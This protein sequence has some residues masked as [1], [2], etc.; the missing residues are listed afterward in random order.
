MGTIDID[1]TTEP[2][3]PA[4]GIS[5]IYIDSSSKKL[6]TKDD[7]GVVTDYSTDTTDHRALTNIGSNTHAQVD[8]HI[9]S[10]ANPHTVD[11]DDVTP[12]TTKGDIIVE[13]GTNAIRVAVGSNDQVLTADSAEAS[14][15]KWAAVGASTPTWTSF[16]PNLLGGGTLTYT[17]S[18]ARY[19]ITGKLLYMYFDW[20]QTNAGSGAAILT[21]DVPGAVTVLDQGNVGTMTALDMGNDNVYNQYGLKADNA[22]NKIQM[23][24]TNSTLLIQGGAN[25]GNNGFGRHMAIIAPLA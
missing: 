2:D 20:I 4:S 3:T 18:N 16:T 9:A 1:N 11:I 6:S 25:I 12:T 13:D 10:T 17:T 14:G 21:V 22:T 23:Y 15:V 19:Y 5:E 24:R 8:T 7:A